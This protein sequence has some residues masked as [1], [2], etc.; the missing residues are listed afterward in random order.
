MFFDDKGVSETI[1]YILVFAIV[2][3][4]IAGIVLFGVTMLND[5]KSRNNIQ[6]I[7]QGFSVVQSDMKRVALEKT[8]IKTSK[9]H[10]EGGAIA[11]N[12]T[13][14]TLQV[15]FDGHHYQNATGTITYQPSGN[16][17]LLSIENGGIWE[18]YGGPSSDAMISAPRI[19]SSPESS[20]LFINV[21]C[22]RGNETTF[23][24]SG[25]INLIMKYA[26]NTVKTYDASLP[27]DA[28]ITI[29]TN[30]PSAWAR[31]FQDSIDGLPVN[32]V[33]VDNTTV[34]VKISSVSEVVVSEHTILLE[35]FVYTS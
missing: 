26:G 13:T 1:G 15:D 14:S 30:Y 10:V 11:T 29:Q 17:Q 9:M 21:I 28:T 4:G 12:Y 23:G 24:G 33:S 5:A 27:S 6:N 34:T 22:L 32:T 3:T 25:T 2:L 8:P 18:I 16:N 31:F 19:Y 7:Q 20:T 35:P